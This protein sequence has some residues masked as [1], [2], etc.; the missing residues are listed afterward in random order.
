MKYLI[1]TVPSFLLPFKYLTFNYTMGRALL[2]KLPIMQP[3]R[4]FPAFYGT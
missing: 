1:L 3:L 2:E 4:K